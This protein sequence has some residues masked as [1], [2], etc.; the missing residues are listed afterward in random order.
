[1][2]DYIKFATL[3]ASGGTRPPGLL[4]PA[5][6]AKL[7]QPAPQ[8]DYAMGW[9]VTNRNWAKGVALNHNGSNT[10]NYFVVW[11]A[12]KTQFALAVASNAAGGNVPKVL[13]D[14]AAALVGRFA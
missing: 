6:I 12:P 13:D 3:H 9:S 5:S 10:M 11:L 2:L 8:Q 1:V 4:L 7:H 14:V